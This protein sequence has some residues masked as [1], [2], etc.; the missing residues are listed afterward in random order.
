MNFQFRLVVTFV[1]ELKQNIK[2]EILPAFTVIENIQ[3]VTQAVMSRFF[4]KY[5]QTEC[6]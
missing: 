2:K 4:S 1:P 6:V 3:F 5:S